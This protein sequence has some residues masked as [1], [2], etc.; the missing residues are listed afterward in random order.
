MVNFENKAVSFTLV[1]LLFLAL[2]LFGITVDIGD[3][4]I[5][6]APKSGNYILGDGDGDGTIGPGDVYIMDSY[7][8]GAGPICRDLNQ[9]RISCGIVLDIIGP[10][11]LITEMQRFW[12]RLV[13]L[14]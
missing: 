7:I 3:S 9:V 2:S 13:L 8:A 11:V 14:K 5:L 4:R 12:Q 10:K 1:V 6:E